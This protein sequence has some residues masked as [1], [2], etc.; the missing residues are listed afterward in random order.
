[1]FLPALGFQAL[2]QGFTVQG[3]VSGP[4][5]KCLPGISVKEQGGGTGTATDSAGFFSLLVSGSKARLVFSAAGYH[6]LVV[7]AETP[8][9]LTISLAPSGRVNI[10]YGT[11]QQQALTGAV[12]ELK[13]E[14]LRGAPAFNVSNTLSGRLAGL[15]AV[16]TSGE[17]GNDGATLRV[18]GVNTFGSTGPLIVVDGVAGRSLQWLDPTTI[19]SISV[20]KDASAAIYG[21]QGANGVILVT[22]K[23]GQVGKP[24]FKASLSQGW[25]Q[26]TRLPELTDAATYATILNELDQYAGRPARYTPEDIGQYTDGSDPWGHPNTDWF[27]EALKPRAGQRQAGIEVSGGSKKLQYYS[28][29][30]TRGQDGLFK[31]SN[32]RYNQHD[33]RTNLDGQLGRHIRLGLGLAGRQENRL[34]VQNGNYIFRS[35]IWATPT[36]IG[37]WPNGS[38]GPSFGLSTNP[39]VLAS[40]SQGDS[41]TQRNLINTNFN[42]QVNVPWV[43]GLSFAG[44]AAVD[45]SSSHHKQV[46]QAWYENTWDDTSRDAQ[47]QPILRQERRD[48]FFNLLTREDD[49]RQSLFNG[50]FQYERTIASRHAVGA[51]AGLE[52]MKAGYSASN[53]SFRYPG[54]ASATSYQSM[55][56]VGKKAFGRVFYGFQHKYQVESTWAYQGSYF[57]APANRFGFF[58]GLALSYVVSQ[59]GFWQQHLAGINYFKLRSSYGKT[60]NSSNALGS[61]K[62]PFGNDDRAPLPKPDNTT[63]ML[64]P[65]ISWEKA[66]QLN[67]G[68]DA[69]LFHNQLS[70]T[71]DYFKYQR[72]DMIQEAPVPGNG[73]TYWL[74]NDGIALNR[75]LDF[76][77]AYRPA[78]RRRVFYEVEM[79]GGFAKSRVMELDENPSRPEYQK[80]KGGPIP[81]IF[82]YGIS[83]VFYQAAGIYKGQA[84]QEDYQAIT[85]QLRHGDILF[86]DLNRDGKI[87][88]DDQ[89]RLNKNNVPTLTGGM[90]LKM[91][92]NRFDFAAL[93]QGAAGA[94]AYNF[95]GYTG[96]SANYLQSWADKRWS[97]Q[98]PEAT[99]P[100]AYHAEYWS[101]GNTYW[102][103]KTD[104]LRLKHVEVGYTLPEFTRR[105]KI[106]SLRAYVNASNL[107]TYSPDYPDFDPELS[108]QAGQYYPLLKIVNGGISLAL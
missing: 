69:G 68:F 88:P 22:T 20:L 91:G 82:V 39:V 83:P 63:M 85:Q 64:D 77:L 40:A 50:L 11:R 75:G 74:R 23:R 67:L 3:Q 87:D 72:S 56:G 31:N 55:S 33:F 10:G 101:G 45:R 13:E 71:M 41:R 30:S 5:G 94:I 2:G 53:A 14:E 61:P 93:L 21:M 105:Y 19:A 37:Y 108:T 107:F 43:T 16:G 51:L 60:G 76:S 73:I 78:P 9:H 4:A 84:P 104:Y 97:P 59:E 57:Y 52:L 79:N 47:G 49:R 8:G 54:A 80:T 24:A 86:K 34:N 90:T 96:E 17:P 1:M 92:Y 44:N 35:L 106:K 26:P 89:M 12:A 7:R 95:T 62:S 18:R 27:E 36:R 98:H 6:T 29:L 25:G 70:L 103:R 46:H 102:L 99:D 42:L 100:R 32:S 48:E 38:F 15:M 58:P 66:R 65:W 81:T 28:A